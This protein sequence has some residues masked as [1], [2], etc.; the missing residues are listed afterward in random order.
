MIG[1]HFIWLKGTNRGEGPVAPY[2][3]CVDAGD[4]GI[5]TPAAAGAADQLP[6][7]APLAAHVPAA[8]AAAPQSPAPAGVVRQTG[9]FHSNSSMGGFILP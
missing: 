3:Q 9:R 1:S 6:G 8:A 7:A 4:A 5:Q 2:S